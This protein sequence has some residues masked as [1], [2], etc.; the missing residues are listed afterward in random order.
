MSG[1]VRVYTK[2]FTFADLQA[3]LTVIITA[4]VAA[5]LILGLTAGGPTQDFGVKLIATI[6]VVV[7]TEIV[8]EGLTSVRRVDIDDGGVT[9]YYLFNKERGSWADLRPSKS[10]A[11]HEM[12]VVVRVSKNGRLRSHW[13]T[14][15][16]ANAVLRFPSR[17]AWEFREGVAESLRLSARGTE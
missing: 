7:L 17:P 4:P 15:P 9:F 12:W 2:G 10:P 3:Q 16:Q 5:I 11:K 1:P 13:I 6:S 8:V 14:L